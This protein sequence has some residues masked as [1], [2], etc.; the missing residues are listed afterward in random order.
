VITLSDIIQNTIFTE[1]SIFYFTPKE[2]KYSLL[3]EYLSNHTKQT[4]ENEIVLVEEAMNIFK[5]NNKGE[6]YDFIMDKR[7]GFNNYDGKNYAYLSGGMDF[8]IGV[9]YDEINDKIILKHAYFDEFEIV[10]LEDLLLLLN[11]VRK[12]IYDSLTKPC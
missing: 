1:E 6:I 11:Q 9:L 5:I 4:I 12:L 10:N 3:C 2:F 7:I 8:S